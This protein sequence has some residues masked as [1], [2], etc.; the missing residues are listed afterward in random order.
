MND[1]IFIYAAGFISPLII[2]YLFKSKF[3][4]STSNNNS[5]IMIGGTAMQMISKNGHVKI[6][7]L[8]KS[9]NVNGKK[10]DYK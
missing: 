6:K 5:Q 7:G 10:I 2:K 4:G 8:L 3:K 9:L 1:Y